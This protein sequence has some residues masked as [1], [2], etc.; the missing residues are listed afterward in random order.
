MCDC[1][2][3]RCDAKGCNELIPIHIGDFCTDRDNLEV[4]CPRHITH[5]FEKY[6]GR[7]WK[8]KKEEPAEE[9]INNQIPKGYLCG[10]R[11]KD[12]TKVLKGYNGSVIFPNSSS[13]VIIKDYN[14]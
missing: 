4:L 8:W 6:N 5:N 3:H 7:I 2:E 14:K 13:A 9:G 11:I 10:I 1:Y 12:W